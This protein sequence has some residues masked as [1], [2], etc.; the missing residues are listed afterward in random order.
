MSYFEKQAVNSRT[1]V[2]CA[3]NNCLQSKLASAQE[4]DTI[5]TRLAVVEASSQKK[6]H[7]TVADYY[8]RLSKSGFEGGWSIKI[9]RKFLENHR[10]AFEWDVPIN[11]P[12]KDLS[13]GRFFIRTR[14]GTAKHAIAIV[15]GMLF[16]SLKEQ[17]VPWTGDPSYTILLA[18]R[19]LV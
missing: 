7:K 19:V 18:C 13:L 3:L 1:C 12:M 10:I 5:A 17:P 11:D 6:T 15:N 4:L 9:V 2:L 16:D 8:H 14:M